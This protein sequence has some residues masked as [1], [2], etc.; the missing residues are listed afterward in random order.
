MPLVNSSYI[1][2]FDPSIVHNVSGSAESTS[3]ANVQLQSEG[4][5]DNIF[6]PSLP[7]IVQMG[8]EEINS[9]AMS[10]PTPVASEHIEEVPIPKKFVPILIVHMVTAGS[11]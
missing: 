1:L 11:T 2:S 7:Y 10:S 9:L 6:S 5:I 8:V 4:F 3:P